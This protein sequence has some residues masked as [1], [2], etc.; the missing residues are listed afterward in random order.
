VFD[1]D[2]AIV[3]GGLTGTALALALRDSGWRVS[4]IEAAAPPAAAPAPAHAKDIDPADFDTRV[5]AL[6]LRTQRFLQDI[7]VWSRV[8]ESRYCPYRHMTVWD[9]D[10]T[11]AIEFD[12]AELDAEA[13]GFLV[14]NRVIQQALNAGLLASGV[15][16]LWQHPVASCEL[17]SDGSAR[18]TFAYGGQLRCRLLVA[19]DGGRSPLRQ[20]L[21]FAT[22]EWSYGQHAI[23]TTV[24]TSAAHSD[25]AW[26]RFLPSGPLAFLPLGGDPLQ[27]FSSIVWSVDSPLEPELMAQDDAA[28]ARSL[29]RAFE[30]RLGCVEAV[31]PR[32]S[33]PLRQVHAIDYVKP[34]VALLGDAAHVIHPLAGQ[35][36]NLGFA[37]AA[38]LAE[39]LH[40]A[41]RRGL[42]PGEL[43]VLRRYQRRRK[44]DNLML[45]AAMEGY[46][47]L[48]GHPDLAVR[49]LRNVGLRR[50]S[51]VPPLKH[52]MMRRAMGVG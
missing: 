10:G 36:V 24:R 25:T 47:R 19:A 15:Q 32:Q 48:F 7:G 52:I 43:M 34:G 33:F 4:L 23:V 20:S 50:V 39:E 35:G 26:Q 27:R 17:G 30:Q 28:F 42:G 12:A 11:G 29:E 13:L 37:D 14:E 5:S 45:M 1:T 3:G 40:W 41:A 22:R 18:L 49:W 6:T 31:G 44:G 51:R 2:I 46:K 38:V 16:V 8:E 9:A 21:G